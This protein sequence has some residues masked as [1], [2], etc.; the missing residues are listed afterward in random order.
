MLENGFD[1]AINEA[2]EIAENIGVEPK[3]PIK[4]EMLSD[5]AYKGEH[6]WTAIQI[7]E[8]AKEMDIISPRALKINGPALQPDIH[9]P[10]G[11]TL[12]S[13]ELDYADFIAIVYEY[14][15]I[16]PMYVDHF[17]NTNMQE[18][19]EEHKEE[20][21]DNIVEEVLDGAGVAIWMMRMKMK[22]KM[23]M[24]MKIRMTMGLGDM[25]V[26]EDEDNHSSPYFI[27]KR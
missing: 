25:D 18:W 21:V 20:V 10:K 13:N 12:I 3:F 9:F 4:R 14:G 19:L 5:E 27:K 6:P 16:L 17:G 8:F 7:M 22:M 15:V 23:R 2:K 11:L 26:D 24:R 1:S